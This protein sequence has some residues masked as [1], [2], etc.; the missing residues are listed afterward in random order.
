MRLKWKEVLVITTE[1]K[2]A[3]IS[4]HPIQHSRDWYINGPNLGIEVQKV[5][6]MLASFKKTNLN[7]RLYFSKGHRHFQSPW[8][9]YYGEDAWTVTLWCYPFMCLRAAE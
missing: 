1:G 8:K 5:I 2:N 4:A 9:Q 7:V 6:S 3:L